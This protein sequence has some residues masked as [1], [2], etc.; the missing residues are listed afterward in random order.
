MPR[1]FGAEI[2][3]LKQEIQELKSLLQEKKSPSML[4]K[5]LK[6][7][8]K[9]ENEDLIKVFEQLESVRT[10]RK[11]TG[12]VSYVG[13]FESSG[14]QSI[15]VR[16]AISTDFLLTLNDNHMAEK[17][18]S[19]IGNSQRLDILLALLKKPMT[20]AQMVEALDLKTT[21]QA[22]HHLK[23]L[24]AADLVKEDPHGEKGTY[25][26]IPHRV[27]GILMMLAGVWDMVDNRY[28]SGTWE[29]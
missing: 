15:W 17:V 24:M 25:T 16:D 4:G 5:Q 9:C 10:E 22:Y 18:L 2:D 1:D 12:A 7:S 26:V 3:G 28:T 21:G 8:I 14:N 13:T 11:D 6:E 19:S 20:V 29:E 27:Q 23:S